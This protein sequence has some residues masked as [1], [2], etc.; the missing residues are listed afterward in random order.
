[1]KWHQRFLDLAA[2]VAGWSKDP[3]TKVGAVAVD[4]TSRAVLSTGYNGLPRGVDDQPCRM[5]RPGKYL[6]T[7]HAEENL[8]AHAA[9][10]TLHGATVY[11][12]HLC[13][14]NCTRMLINAGVSKIVCGPGLTNMDYENFAVARQMLKEADVELE[15]QDVQGGEHG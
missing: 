7:A 3:S 14:A 8:V 13:C 9:R 5:Q 1:M 12:T 10:Q 11:V 2:H 6:W 4:P 15:V